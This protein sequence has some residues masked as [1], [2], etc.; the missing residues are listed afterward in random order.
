MRITHLFWLA[1][2][3]IRLHLS[4]QAEERFI[5]SLPHRML[6]RPVR[7]EMNKQALHSFEDA[8]VNTLTLQQSKEGAQDFYD[9]EVMIQDIVH[10]TLKSANNSESGSTRVQFLITGV[11]FLNRTDDQ[12]QGQLGQLLEFSF[13]QN[14]SLGHF[15]F[16][17]N[18]DPV[19]GS[20]STVLVRPMASISNVTSDQVESDTPTDPLISTLDIIL[21]CTSGTILLG[22]VCMLIQHH[23]DRG[24][25]EIQRL[26]LFNRRHHDA[27]S[28]STNARNPGANTQEN[29]SHL[30]S[31]GRISSITESPFSTAVPEHCLSPYRRF[32]SENYTTKWSQP[33][34]TLSHIRR[35]I[36]K[37]TAAFIKADDE[38]NSVEEFVFEDKSDDSVDLFNVDMSSSSIDSKSN[39]AS[40]VTE[41]MKTIRVV[42]TDQRVE[43]SPVSDLCVDEE[44]RVARAVTVE[45]TVSPS[46]ASSPNNSPSSHVSLASSSAS[47]SGFST[48]T[49]SSDGSVL[50]DALSKLN[51]YALDQRSLE[52]SMASSIVASHA[53]EKMEV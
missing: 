52:H 7:G 27:P 32:L 13:A 5:S 22:I 6:L 20:V 43:S 51:H 15:L 53:R 3:S 1:F 41:W 48:G 14:R 23:K 4:V 11:T 28:A 24:Y 45:T 18:S 33:Q 17:I 2:A 44:D 30:E 8:I 25:I 16:L 40:A 10:L 42:T 29:E 39:A 31:I 9:N 49:S 37:S 12:L 46:V 47:S 50:A 38:D 36:T 21:M 26:V 35:N 19:L 34:R